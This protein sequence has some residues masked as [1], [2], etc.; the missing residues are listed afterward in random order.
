MTETASGRF[1]HH[2]QDR[3]KLSS[4]ALVFANLA[5]LAGVLFFGWTFSC[6]IVRFRLLL[7]A[8]S[9]CSSIPAAAQR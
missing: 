2:M 6:I 9:R 3:L 8:T 5:P 1:A 7:R 4:L